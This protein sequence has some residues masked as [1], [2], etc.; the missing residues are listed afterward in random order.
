VVSEESAFVSPD[1]W[2]ELLEHHYGKEPQNPNDACTLRP[3][4]REWRGKDSTI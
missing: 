3:A 1:F 4:G 2:Q